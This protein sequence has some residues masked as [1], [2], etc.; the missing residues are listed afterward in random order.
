MGLEKEVL[1]DLI[2]KILSGDQEAFERF[3]PEYVQIIRVRAGKWLLPIKMASMYIYDFE[4]LCNEIWE[5]VF[6]RL[7]YYDSSKSSMTT[8]LYMVCGQSC[9]RIAN[10]YNRKFRNPGED[11]YSLDMELGE[12]E[13]DLKLL[14]LVVDP[15]HNTEDE[16]L[17][18][19]MLYEYIY[20]LK[21][22]VKSLNHQQQIVYLHK[23]KG[24]PLQHSAD[25][26]CVSRQRV[27]QIYNKIHEKVLRKQASL[28]RQSYTKSDHFAIS[29]LSNDD[30]DIISERLGCDLATVK[31]CREILSITGLYCRSER[32]V[33]ND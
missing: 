4:D 11:I 16:V 18:E 28:N 22:F 6:R 26:L 7:P 9:E 12:D 2:P 31:I 20:F 30:D 14:D 15:L 5:F 17:S 29:L 21:D 23:I 19:I 1:D 25:I 32:I 3:Y 33:E 13:G 24:Y 27:D 10:H 8:F